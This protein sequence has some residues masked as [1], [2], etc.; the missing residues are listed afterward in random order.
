M[1]FIQSEFNIVFSPQGCHAW[2]KLSSHLCCNLAFCSDCAVH[3][4]VGGH[5][6]AHACVRARARLYVCVMGARVIVSMTLCKC[7]VNGLMLLF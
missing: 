2:D 7:G 3:M 1:L 6:H 4:R 5:T